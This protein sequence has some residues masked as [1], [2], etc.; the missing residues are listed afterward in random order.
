MDQ[1]KALAIL[2]FFSFTVLG[3]EAQRKPAPGFYADRR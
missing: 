3:S 2:L 1:F